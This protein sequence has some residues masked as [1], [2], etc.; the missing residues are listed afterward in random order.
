MMVIHTRVVAEVMVQSG[1]ISYSLKVYPPSNY[2]NFSLSR[3]DF[4]S[5]WQ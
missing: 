4:K 2:R 3:V 5:L 1:Q